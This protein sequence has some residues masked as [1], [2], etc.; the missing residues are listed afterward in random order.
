MS[1]NEIDW[2][3]WNGSETTCKTDGETRVKHIMKRSKKHVWSE[4][5]NGPRP[6]CHTRSRW[7]IVTK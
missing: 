2:W 4:M 1:L 7:Q 6:T 3:L 5:K